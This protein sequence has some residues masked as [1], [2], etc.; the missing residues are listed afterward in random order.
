MNTPEPNEVAWP[1]LL[2]CTPVP[3]EQPG[4]GLLAGREQSGMLGCNSP[5]VHHPL[6]LCPYKDPSRTPVEVTG[7]LLHAQELRLEGSGL[8]PP[9]R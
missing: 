9:G 4:K 5:A 2:G 8:Q 1:A 6:S 3:E 7:H